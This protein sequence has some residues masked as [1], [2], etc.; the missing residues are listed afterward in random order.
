MLHDPVILPE[1]SALALDEEIRFP[2]LLFSVHI[3][4]D[5][6]SWGLEKHSSIPEFLT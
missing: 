3:L 1:S 2:L 4:V 6:G 5:V